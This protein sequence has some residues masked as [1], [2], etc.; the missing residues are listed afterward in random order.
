MYLSSIDCS[1]PQRMISSLVESRYSWSLPKKL[2]HSSLAGNPDYPLCISHQP[3][4]S[5]REPW[6]GYPRSLSRTASLRF[7][8]RP[9]LV[10]SIEFVSFFSLISGFCA[11]TSCT[12]FAVGF[13]RLNRYAS[14]TLPEVWICCG[15]GGR[16]K[17]HY[18]LL[19]LHG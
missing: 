11:W 1:T 4:S 18:A 8:Q 15:V 12:D 6:R 14:T 16:F 9:G 13:G 10:M 7:N 2:N 3:T 17:A 5:L 19:W